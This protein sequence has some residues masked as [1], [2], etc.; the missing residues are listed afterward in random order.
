MTNIVAL[1]VRAPSRLLSKRELARELGRSTRWVEM[2]MR[3]GL[4]VTARSNPREHAR[5][6]LARVREWL[7]QRPAA[8]EQPLAERVAVLEAQVARLTGLLEQGKVSA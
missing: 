1:P 8:P 2:R 3:E 7:D 5:Y 6:D 4:P